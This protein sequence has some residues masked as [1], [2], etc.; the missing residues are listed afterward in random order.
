MSIHAELEAAPGRVQGHR[1]RAAVRLRLPR[2]HRHD[3]RARPAAARSSSPTSSTTP[4]SSTAAG[5]PAPR[6]SSTATRTPS[7]SSGGCARA[8]G[9][10]SLIVTDGVF[11]M[12]GDVAPLAELVE[13]ARRHRCRLMVD[14]A[15]A[16]GC[17]GPGGRGSVAAAGLTDEVDVIVGTLGKALGRLRRLRLRLGRADRL[18]GQLRAA[19]HLLHRARRRRPSRPPRPPSSCSR[20]ARS[21]SSGC[22]PTPP[23]CATGAAR[24]GLEPAGSETQIVPLVVGEAGRC[25]GALRAAARAT[26]SSRRR[27]GRPPS[28][29]GPAACA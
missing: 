23:R 9:R 22:A 8:A 21:G 24:R 10:G 4:A 26:A 5:W 29:P 14:E 1:G 15:H 19:V 6:P 17:V 25:H 12:D 11:S 28:L 20:S 18:P 3:R 7:T 13:L 27:S 16:T 2:Q